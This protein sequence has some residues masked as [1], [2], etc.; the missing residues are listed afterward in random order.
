MKEKLLKILED[1]KVED[2]TV[3]DLRMKS[4]LFDFFIIGTVSSNK[5]V[6]AIF[7]E[8]K[9]SGIDIHH[10]EETADGGWT[11]IDCFDVVIHLFTEQKRKEY[12]LDSLWRE[13]EKRRE[14]E[15]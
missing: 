13:T 14:D 2:I 3:Y 11:L 10:I 5:Q 6:Y 15:S 9:K 4:A 8:I 1:K 7:D 12:D